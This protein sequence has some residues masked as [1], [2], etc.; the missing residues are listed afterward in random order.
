[1]DR[2]FAKMHARYGK[3]WLDMWQGLPLD[4]V[5]AEW[6]N[7]LAGLTAQDIR[8]GLDEC[9]TMRFPPTL[10]EFKAMC[11]PAAVT[12]PEQLFAAACRG[13]ATGEWRDPVTYWTAVRV[14]RFDV[15]GS[16]WSGIR[17]RWL[18]VLSEVRREARDGTL[19]D[20]PPRT[21]A[22]PAPGQE[23]IDRD[24]ARQRLAEIKARLG[25]VPFRI[26][27]GKD[28]AAA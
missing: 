9:S 27:G 3:H 22:L 5:R 17:A 26:V 21:D 2:I 1:M 12:D 14:G 7:E 23:S 4:A 18:D 11:R 15:M 16:A 19:A 25:K 8:A 6:G 24:T 10:G 13:F 28:D 20:I